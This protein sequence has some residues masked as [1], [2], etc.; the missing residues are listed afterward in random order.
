MGELELSDVA[1]HSATTMQGSNISGIDTG[2][3]DFNVQP[4][5]MAWLDVG[6]DLP[7]WL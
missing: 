2:Q 5:I 1:D 6:L 7:V 4:D 3:F